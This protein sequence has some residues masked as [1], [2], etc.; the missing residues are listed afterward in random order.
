MKNRKEISKRYYERH[1]A[2]C[3]A[4]SRARALNNP[5]EA[6]EYSKRSYYKNKEK[7]AERK[8]QRML[9]DPTLTEKKRLYLRE[10]RIKNRDKEE[11]YKKKYKADP[12]K[13]IHRI[14]SC[15]VWGM[16]RGEKGET[17]TNILGYDAQALIDHL[18]KTMPEGYSWNDYGRDGLHIDHIIPKSSFKVT[19]KFC[20][21]LKQCW[22]LSNLRLLPAKENLQKYNKIVSIASQPTV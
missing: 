22:A 5:E 20:E 4:A 12:T 2:K 16:L 7:W 9:D 1:K 14:V 21:E 13:R 6:K 10:W 8:K 11:T 17:W 18:S 19:D 3:N 15:A